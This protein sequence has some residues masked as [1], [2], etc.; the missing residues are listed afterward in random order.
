VLYYGNPSTPEIRAAMSAGT[1]G[2]VLTPGQGNLLPDGAPWCADNG[3]FGG[4]FRGYAEWW[5]WL[6]SHRL[7]A[8]TCAFAVA[9]DV[10]FDYGLTRLRSAE[11][12]S[13]IRGLGFPAAFCLQDGV[14]MDAELPWDQF[15]V[16]FIAG[17]MP[18][19]S[20]VAAADFTRQAAERG[21]PVHW[22]RCN[23][24]KRIKQAHGM[25]CASADG[26]YLRHGPD[27]NLGRL[28]G[29]LAELERNGAQVFI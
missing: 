15:D 13:R 22:G 12:L 5:K 17:S 29:W 9:P 20:S 1:I 16:L 23:S 27:I 14:T 11:W 25:G 18:F 10:P 24:L 4:G 3:C 21:K 19:K 28:L 8:A 2:C 26:G 6:A 7:D